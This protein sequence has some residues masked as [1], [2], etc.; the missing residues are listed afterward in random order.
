MKSIR[1]L[2]L[3]VAGFFFALSA[4]AT[5][6]TETVI[7]GKLRTHLYVPTTPHT[8]GEGRA[9]MVNLH[10][11]D[12]DSDDMQAGA[13][14]P[15][16]ADAYG[17]VVAVPNSSREGPWSTYNCWNYFD[18]EDISRTS[19]DAKY[20]L[21]MVDA[22]L[23]KPDLN[24]DPKQVYIS[25]LSSGAAIAASLAC[26]APEVFAG[27][28]SSAG[29]GPGASGDVS[30]YTNPDL[31]VPEATR[32]CETM[33][34]RNSA[35]IQS[36]SN[37]QIYST[38]AGSSDFSISPKWPGIISD[39]MANV[40]DVSD[41][42]GGSN[43]TSVSGGGTINTYCDADGP[44]IT[45]IVV[46]GMG[47]AWSAGS[48][49]SGGGTYMT[50]RYVD[51][52]AY[53]T[54]FLFANNRRVTGN[55][56]P[57]ISDFSVTEG[58]GTITASGTATDNDGSVE[59]IAIQ[60]TRNDNLSVVESF[61]LIVNSAG[62]FSGDT[63]SLADGLYA[64]TAIATDNENVSSKTAESAIWVG[65]MPDNTSPIITGV[66]ASVSGACVTISGVITD[67]EANLVSASASF[68][69]GADIDIEIS[70]PSS[71]NINFEYCDL[72]S[73]SHSVVITAMDSEPSIS[74]SSTV[75]FTTVA[76][77]QAK[78]GDLAW[79]Q[80]DGTISYTSGY[81][82]CG[83]AYGYWGGSEFTVI[84]SQTSD[85]Q[86]QWVDAA[87]A[88]GCVGPAQTCSGP[89]QT[90]TPVITPTPTPVITPTPT[91][92]PLCEHV[93]AYN[94]YHKQAGRAFSSGSYWKPVYFAK[95]SKE[96]ILGSTWDISVLRSI[97]GGK[98][99]WV[100][101]CP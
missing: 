10:G 92:L 98:N 63:M 17:M 64:V 83:S 97:D 33:L 19:K 99:W 23:N 69:G 20:L 31:T 82:S 95:G 29:M 78:T 4:H 39:A 59:N 22:L 8:L 48:D 12:M 79:H 75:S 65:I 28:G 1:M 14:W 32:N 26:M 76:V 13:G 41:C 34:N 37:T 45:N 57:I 60:V 94:Y 71:N 100:G 81:N 15:T 77:T 49:S 70:S 101:A 87:G 90:P 58:N 16:T 68:N 38:I 21:D 47:H 88:S 86:C 61:D 93:S 73:G 25:G 55:V 52:P 85:G 24:I 36:E 30:S 53:L 44:R 89:V 50:H 3:A 2:M 74:S 35:D 66:S 91:P 54:E 96:P 40:Y 43:P 7:G 67:A 56:A 27:V 84:E 6:Q 80:T 42:S 9:L 62:Y 46:S 18:A 5:W 51:Y 72:T 11:C